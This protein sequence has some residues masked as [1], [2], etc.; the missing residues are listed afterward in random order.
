MASIIVGTGPK[1][2]IFLQL[3]RKTTVLGRDEAVSMQIEDERAS[4]K[5][6]Q[7]RFEPSDNQYRLLDMSSTNGTYINGKRIPGEVLL[8]DGDEISIGDT[9]IMFVLEDPTDKVS[10]LNVFKKVGER[11]RSTLIR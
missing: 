3:G 10:A 8:T 9:K 6:C 2:G 7:I 1:Q 11:R 5:H 4:R